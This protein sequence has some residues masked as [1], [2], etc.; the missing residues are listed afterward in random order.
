MNVAFIVSHLRLN[1]WEIRIVFWERH[2]F[3]INIQGISIWWSWAAGLFIPVSNLWFE[4]RAMEDK[5]SFC[6]E[7]RRKLKL[8][9]IFEIGLT[10]NGIHTFQIDLKVE[11]SAR[12][13]RNPYFSIQKTPKN[14][15]N[16]SIQSLSTQTT[17]KTINPCILNS[18]Q[19]IIFTEIKAFPHNN[20]THRKK[21]FLFDIFI[22]EYKSLLISLSEQKEVSQFTISNSLS[23][24]WPE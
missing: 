23:F 5:T 10:I 14:R 15:Y 18:N 21:I 3:S 19:L 20:D 2:F 1:G 12:K 9:T 17:H 4:G 13:G 8:L 24:F 11:M 7:F 22:I 16:W 6:K